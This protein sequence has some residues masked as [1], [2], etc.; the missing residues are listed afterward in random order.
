MW[1]NWKWILTNDF[2]PIQLSFATTAWVT[3]TAHLVTLILNAICSDRKKIAPTIA[4]S[5]PVLTN[6]I[7][8]KLLRKSIVSWTTSQ[9]MIVK[10]S[11]IV[12]LYVKGFVLLC[13]F[14]YHTL[15]ESNPR[16]E[17]QETDSLQV[18]SSSS[19]TGQKDQ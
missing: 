11:P 3:V 6:S 8:I 10:M 5:I 1:R 7:S 17:G 14:L 19:L 4:N 18:L 15:F 12:W 13:H 9:V 16:W 2:K